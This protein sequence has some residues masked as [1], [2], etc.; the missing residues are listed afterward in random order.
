MT[1]ARYRTREEIES[2][3]GDGF[4][5]MRTELIETDASYAGFD[6]FWSV[7]ERRRRPCGCVACDA[8]R[9]AA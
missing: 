2:L 4:E 1:D 7:L 9:R 5:K 6:E 8:R 3:F